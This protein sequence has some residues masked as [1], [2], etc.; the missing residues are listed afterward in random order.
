M[1]PKQT[2]AVNHSRNNGLSGAVA[3]SGG[4]GELLKCP[5]AAADGGTRLPA[6]HQNSVSAIRGEKNPR[7]PWARFRIQRS[8]INRHSW[9]R[10]M[11][12]SD[13]AV[14]V[15]RGAGRVP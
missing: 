3:Q 5:D 1:T 9:M 2:E 8:G 7:T 15:L 13:R 10:T 14:A 11:S 12:S 4:P 6:V